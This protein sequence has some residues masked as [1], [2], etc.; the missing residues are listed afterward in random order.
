LPEIGAFARLSGRPDSKVA[1]AAHKF[2]ALRNEIFASDSVVL[3]GNIGTR[4][5]EIAAH[6]LNC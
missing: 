3:A 4:G 5:V 1:A 6:G 2:H